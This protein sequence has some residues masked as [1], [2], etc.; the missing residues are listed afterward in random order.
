[1]LQPSVPAWF[2]IPVA[3]IDRAQRFYEA[4]LGMSMKRQRY[5]GDTD[6]AVFPNG[7]PDYASGALVQANAQRAPSQSI[8]SLVYLSVR[9]IRPLLARVAE[10]GG[11]VLLPL[12]PITDTP[13][14]IG[15]IRDSEGNRVGLASVEVAG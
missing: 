10:L 13:V 1:M 2:E 4:L 15:H 7:G 6:Q 14:V 8:G 3:D 9:D 5:M 12:T 11:E